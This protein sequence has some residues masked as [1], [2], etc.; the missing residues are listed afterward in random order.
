MMGTT[1]LVFV[2][3]PG[4]REAEA[5]RAI[6]ACMAWLHEVDRQLTRFALGSELC[7][8]NAD[9][10]RWHS[11]T[12][13]AFD[14]IAEALRAARV[15]DGLFDPTLLPILEDL[16]YDRDYALIKQREVEPGATERAV[17]ERSVRPSGAWREI[18]MDARGPRVRL[19]PDARLD[20]G[21]IAKGWAADVAME[22]FFEA[23]HDV[24]V[25]LG[26]DMRVRGGPEDGGCWP[27]G[28]GDPRC[29]PADQPD[30]TA[31]VLTLG[32]GGLATSGAN[33]RWWTRRGQRVHHLIDPRSGFPIRLWL[34][35]RDDGAPEPP[36]AT[37]SALAP[38]AA[39]AEVA[40][41]VALLRGEPEARL[42]VESAWPGSASDAPAYGDADVALLLVRGSGEVACS[43][44]LADYL[45]TTGGGG[46]VWLD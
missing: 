21:G 23:F 38:T 25:N 39:H 12:Q 20:L 27:L 45:A 2:A 46:D 41:K 8:L 40:A 37:A 28:I 35:A 42:A 15:T 16:G 9:A 6:D 30:R 5:Q 10:G 26:G 7:Q 1:A 24:I 34:D 4:E 43:S 44:N 17:T 14:A 18:E 31:A 36:I 3:A 32:S 29:D 19:P 22:R 33:L 13:L 11:V